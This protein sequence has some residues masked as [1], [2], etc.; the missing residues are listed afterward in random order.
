MNT[1][2]PSENALNQYPHFS[3]DSPPGHALISRIVQC[4]VP[5]VPHD[6]VLEGVGKVLDG[7]DLVAITPTG[8]GKT[9]YMA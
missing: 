2:T 3:F 8:S 7:S 4:Y 6:Y 5:Y 9:G 1:D